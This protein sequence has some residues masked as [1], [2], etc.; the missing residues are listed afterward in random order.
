MRWGVELLNWFKNE[1]NREA[2][3]IMFGILA[4]IIGGGWV[5]YTYFVDTGGGDADN[6]S[7]T[8]INGDGN[9]V[10]PGDG[11]TVNQ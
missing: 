5:L 1:D 4:A 3:K 2:A 7:G 8:S 10:I 11:N 6:H 9:V